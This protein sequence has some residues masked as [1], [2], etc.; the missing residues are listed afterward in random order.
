MRRLLRKAIAVFRKRSLD[1]ELRAELES[2]VEMATEDHIAAGM[3]PVEA[4]RRAR[5]EVGNL[6]V[7]QELHRE[8]RGLPRLESFVQD[9]RYGLRTLGR[10]W[11]F[12]LVA[13]TILALG[14]GANTVVYSFVDA[15][16]LSPLPFAE[17][18]RLVW[19]SNGEPGETNPSGLASRVLTYRAWLEGVDQL[20]EA[21]A[22][23]P[24]F[25]RA[26]WALTGDGREPERLKAVRVTGNFLSVL[27]VS[28]QLGRRFAADE[29]VV[30][31]PRAVIISHGLW[32]RRFE[33]RGGIIGEP[34]ELNDEP[35][36][37][38]GVLP[39]DFDFGSVFEPGYHV[40][41][42]I[43]AILDE[44]DGWGNT[45]AVVGRLAPGATVQSA[46][47]ELEAFTER[48][49]EDR[50]ELA[51]WTVFARTS[52][53]R[54]HVSAPI[55]SALWLLWGAV[56]LVLLIVCAN[57]ANLM[58][59]RGVSRRPEMAIRAALG[60]G[61]ARLFRQLLTESALLAGLGV[62]LGLSLATLT[63]RAI[64][65]RE[66]FALPLL[67]TTRIDGS[68]VAVAALTTLLVTLVVGIVPAIQVGRRDGTGT[69]EKSSRGAVG[70][71][72]QHW[73]RSSLVVAEIA[74][75]C[76]LLIGAGLLIRSFGQLIDVELGFE[77]RNR[78]SFQVSAG[79][80]YRDS[81]DVEEFQRQLLQRL[82]DTP[83][84]EDAAFSDNL[85]LDGNRSWGLRRADRFEDEEVT[86]TAYVRLVSDGYF[87]TMGIPVLSG[88]GFTPD[89]SSGGE[90]V[91]VLNQTAA[92]WLWP[93]GNPVGERV[94]AGGNE[95]RVVGVV[96]DV[97]H[98]AMEEESGSEM[99]LPIAQ[100]GV[101]AA[102]LVVHTEG[103][104]LAMAGAIRA[105]VR[106]VDPRIP[107]NDLQPLE[108]LVDRAVASRRFVTGMLVGFAGLAL[109]LASLGIYG[110]ISYSVGQRRPEI[111]VRL[112]LGAQPGRVLRAEIRR[113]LVM[114]ACGLG[115]GLGGALLASR[116][117]RSLLY[118]VGTTD[119]AT[120]ATMGAVLLG[121]GLLAGY[122][123]ARRA[124]RINPVTALR[125][126]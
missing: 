115:L 7:A 19:I 90:P 113:A 17:P 54:D 5:I 64:V 14:I 27:G 91:I 4:R 98:N 40:D 118:E 109:V 105:A 58:L 37:V 85:P 120:Y 68:V 72:A 71:R 3:E 94:I 102:S 20:E 93:E 103:N 18:E 16:L 80:R 89:D 38:V 8:A 86:G 79:A 12:T 61:R 9:A 114:T 108:R 88:R 78:A 69:L 2:H 75:A 28:P 82:R 92:E 73:T 51:G 66:S 25:T 42:L 110:V 23:S 62:V 81:T 48:L 96:G 70:D 119:A 45:L 52:R 24:F 15:L 106:E 43:P 60:A 57:L 11:P 53:L 77:P 34:I 84:V 30:N 122:L 83:R 26:S 35:W 65:A 126:G 95:R 111:G 22:Y 39:A 112:A 29:V 87:E 100:A 21:A 123:P 49:K 67:E 44:M 121:A 32:E 117:L 124:A 55:R 99:Y 104:P 1:D 10:D 41:L 59:V 63:V 31:G 6:G 116:L 56:G 50:P 36:T 101:R 47:R 33:G 74:L 97:R 76:T 13:V 107:F 125:D 46:A